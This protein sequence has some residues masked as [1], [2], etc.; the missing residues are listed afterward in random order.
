MRLLVGSETVGL[1]P[2]QQE[3]LAGWAA[4]S[5]DKEWLVVRFG[6]PFCFTSQV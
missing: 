2:N 1:R 3:E 5:W 4:G 6:V